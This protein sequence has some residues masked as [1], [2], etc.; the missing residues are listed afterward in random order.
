MMLKRFDDYLQDNNLTREE[1]LDKVS[2][3]YM[4]YCDIPQLASLMVKAFG[5]DTMCFAFEQLI[6]TRVVMEK[7]VKVFDPET[8]EIYGFLVL[9]N[10]KINEGSPIKFEEFALDEFLNGFSQIHGYAFVLDKRLRNTG[11]DKR[12]LS[13]VDYFINSFDFCWLAVDSDLRSNAYWK[14]LGFKEIFSIPEATFYGRF[15]Y[16]VKSADIYYKLLFFNCE[17]HNNNRET[18]EE[19][20]SP[21]N[22]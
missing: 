22:E 14:K 16:N 6:R 12:M 15:S 18:R 7:S 13:M 21:I 10:F 3:S 11:Y 20:H 4:D 19:T 9:S 5:V 2:L 8:D 1:L 17:D